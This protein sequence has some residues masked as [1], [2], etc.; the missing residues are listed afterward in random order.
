MGKFGVEDLALLYE[1]NK[2]KDYFASYE[3]KHFW[4]EFGKVY[5]KTFGI[6]EGHK[7]PLNLNV[8]YL[9]SRIAILKPKSILEVGCGFGR[10]LVFVAANIPAL[11]V[12]GIEFSSTMIESAK[13]FL[14]NHKNQLLKLPA[15]I[16]ADAKNLPFKDKSFDLVYTHVCLTH[17]SPEDIV[18]VRRE[19]SRVARDGIIHIE[20]YRYPYEHD[21]PHVWSHQHIPHYQRLG[22]KLKEYSEINKKHST[23]LLVLLSKEKWQETIKN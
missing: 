11:S 5:I 17:I 10:M 4:E 3:P 14:N 23:K 21:Q 20:R 2:I 19:I 9:L 13:E 15:I 12:V 22:W 16:Q 8:N 1:Q 6:K 18:Q 7:N